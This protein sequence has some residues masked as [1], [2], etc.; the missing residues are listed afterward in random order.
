MGGS[1]D[2]DELPLLVGGKDGGEVESGNEGAEGGVDEGEVGVEELGDGR[3]DDREGEGGEL[4]L[5]RR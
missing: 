5:R 1:G 4:E 3:E 2:D